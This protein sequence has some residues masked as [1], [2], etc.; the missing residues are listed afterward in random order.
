MFKNVLN[1]M[2]TLWVSLFVLKI[3][4][5]LTWEWLYVIIFPIWFP[6]ALASLCFSVI[7][8]IG[9]ILLMLVVLLGT[10]GFLFEGLKLKWSKQ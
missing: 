1:S 7:I 4:D 5:H 9:L 8:G 2:A 6:V 3:L 10:I